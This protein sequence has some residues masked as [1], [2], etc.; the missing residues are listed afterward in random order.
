M[1]PDVIAL[2]LHVD[3]WDYIGW[4][5]RFAQPVFTARQKA[6]AHLVGSNT[7]YT[8]QMIVGGRAQ[9]AGS[10]PEQVERA[11][12]RDQRLAPVV[13]LHLTRHGDQVEIGAEALAAFKGPVL[14]QV[15]RY[16]PLAS[17]QIAYGENAGRVMDYANIVTDWQSLG[18]WDGSRAL[19][20][21]AQA[22]GADPVV[23]ILQAA[24]P[25]EI[26]AAAQIK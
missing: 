14:V 25:G 1:D 7:I 16:H 20:L 5:D 12:R 18:Q 3:Y 21:T 19:Q 26:L 9:V 2:A 24:G 22:A 11:I 8:P 10:D 15:V 6:Y 23:V 13:R 17:V 4:T